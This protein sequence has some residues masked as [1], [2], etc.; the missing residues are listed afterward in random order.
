MCN[1][2]KYLAPV[3]YIA[4]SPEQAINCRWHS[5]NTILNNGDI[6]VLTSEKIKKLGENKENFYL[7]Y[8]LSPGD[9]LVRHPYNEGY[10]QTIDAEDKYFDASMNGMINVARW[11]CATKISYKKY[12]IKEFKREIDNNNNIQYKQIDVSLNTRKK[13]EE[14]F[15]KEESKITKFQKEELTIEKF[16]KA[17]SIAQKRGLY[18][19]EDIRNLFDLRNPELGPAMTSI[20]VNTKISSSLDK[21]LDIAFKLNTLDFF[22]LKSNTKIAIQKRNL[23]NIEWEISF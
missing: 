7:P 14:H 11:L 10:I 6:D 19:S 5:R 1:N 9:I 12:N 8:D 3:I 20:T 16:E 13:I 23:L 2:N 15:L 22:N 17:K 18:L 4:E 21:T